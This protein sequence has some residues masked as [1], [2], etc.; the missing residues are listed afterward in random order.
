MAVKETRVKRSYVA[1]MIFMLIILCSISAV[2]VLFL[3]IGNMSYLSSAYPD[4]KMFINFALGA[5]ILTMCISCYHLS[6]MFRS[7]KR[8]TD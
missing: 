5:F 2:N 3:V 8:N 6:T 4:A 7:R 1:Q